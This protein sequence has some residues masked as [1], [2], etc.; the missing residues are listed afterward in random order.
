MSHGKKIKLQKRS[1]QS[2]RIRKG[3][4]MPVGQGGENSAISFRDF[5]DLKKKY[6]TFQ[7]RL[8]RHPFIL[9]VLLL[10]FA[11]FMFSLILYSRFVE[12]LIIQRLE[13]AAL[14]AI[15]FVVLTIPV[16]WAHLS[17]GTRRCHDLNKSGAVFAVPYI[18][19]LASYVTPLLGWPTVALVVQAITVVSFLALFIIKGTDGDNAY[20]PERAR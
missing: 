1:D 4:S 18:C 17:L 7:G 14:F 13:F 10:A 15:I 5:K 20:G 11:Q 3:L 16:V 9:R 12:S 2:I 6:F 8:Q 19:Y